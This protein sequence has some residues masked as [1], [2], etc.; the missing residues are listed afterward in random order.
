MKKKYITF[1][2]PSYNSEDYL[3]RCIDSLLPGGEDVEIIIVNDGSSDGTKKIADKYAKKYPE[4]VKA[5]HKENG[6]HG[7]GVNTGI[8]NATGIYYKVVDSDDWVDEK[9]YKELLKNIKE[10]VDKKKN[11]DLF[12][13]NYVYNRLEEG[14]TNPVNYKNI[15]KP[16]K[17]STWS[18]MGKFNVSQFLIMH[19]LTFKTEILRKAEVKLPE[20]TFYVDNIFSYKPLP[21]VKNIMYLDVDFYQYYIGREDQSV[22]EK[23]MVKRI[24]Q[25]FKVTRIVMTA[26]DIEK[27]RKTDEVL[28]NYME[29]FVSIML[30]IT[31]AL[32]ALAKT[33][34][35]QLDR[36]KLWKELK[37]YDKKVYRKVRY[38]KVNI[39]TILPNPIKDFLIAKGYKY[40]KK[41]YM[42][43]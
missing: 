42:F 39:V 4:I 38:S 29:R 23:T 25:Q 19:A 41:K 24:D 36:K 11:I 35:S 32:T 12:I 3:E 10:A 34:E 27:I 6:G 2:V 7:S 5:I 22:N 14:L 28:A 30:T 17:I 18:D 21:F 1:A 16:N 13:S 40:A 15:F 26:H 33:K 43:A 8:E 9:A 31:S 37:A 20:H